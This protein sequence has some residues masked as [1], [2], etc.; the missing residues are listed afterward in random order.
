M[1]REKD[2]EISFLG[3]VTIRLRAVTSKVRS[4]NP[5]RSLFERERRLASYDGPESSEE[6][7]LACGFGIARIISV[8]LLIALL[9]LTLLF[10]SGVISYEKVY[11]MFKDI[12]Y[13]KS[14]GESEP[15]ALNYSMPVQNQDFA[16]FKNGLAV[17]GDSEIKMFTSTG[18][19]TMTEGSQFT[20]PRLCASNEY[21]LVYDQGRR[22]YAV[23][24][25]FIG[26]RRENL[27]FP[28]SYADMAEN[29]S[30]LLVTSSKKYASVVKIYDSTLNLIGEYS[31]NDRVISASLSS[32]GRFA[33]VL[34]LSSRDGEAVSSLNVIDTRS[35]SVKY[36]VS[37]DGYMPYT[38]Q[39]LTDDR[40]AVILDGK[41]V[42]FDRGGAQ[43]S[44]FVYKDSLAR[45]DIRGG[46][47]A[48]LFSDGAATNRNSVAVFNKDGTPIFSGTTDGIV[49]DM[50]ISDTAVYFLKSK[51]VVRIS[52][53]T[54]SVARA[55]TIS[56]K[57]RIMVFSDGRVA[58]CT[59][60]TARYIS[61]D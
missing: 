20:N 54:G 32:D 27:D 59:Q 35:C 2:N 6:S 10:G 42:V 50:K 46:R 9:L 23:Y 39:F 30:Y 55:D 22:G 31:K 49:R 61:F 17:A 43:K 58:F 36:S 13:V 26:V 40:I 44:E 51:E 5:T 47:F 7:K 52:T 8:V 53:S 21:V 45:Y 1:K 16:V 15:S 33:A 29:G 28:I 56:E 38:C 11:Y 41:A 60:T 4:K 34:S 57:A 24:N 37:F 3:R 19:M 48:L 18:R 12:G 14:Y 25:S